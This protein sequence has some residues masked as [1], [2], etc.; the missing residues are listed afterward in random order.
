MLFNGPVAVAVDN[1]G[2]LYV[3]DGGNDTIRKGYP[4]SM[5]LASGP[6]FGFNRSKFGF[7]FTG[8]AGQLVVVE[9]STDLV[10]W[11]PIWT[12]TFS[13]ALSFSD[14]QSGAS[15]HRFYRTRTP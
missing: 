2:T 1:E 13:G 15:S 5:I 11:L 12:N 14:P 10:N 6:G 8:P 7:N 9:A 3:V 4:A